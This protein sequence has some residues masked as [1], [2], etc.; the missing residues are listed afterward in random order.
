MGAVKTSKSN[1]HIERYISSIAGGAMLG[2]ITGSVIWV[3]IGG[4]VGM[5]I[6]NILANRDK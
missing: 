3:I 4:L 1:D 5:Y 2:A 6:A